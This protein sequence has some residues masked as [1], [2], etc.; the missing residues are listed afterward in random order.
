MNCTASTA[1]AGAAALR[2]TCLYTVRLK[3]RPRLRR[4][5]T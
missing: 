1:S 2:I 5:R 3:L 4:V